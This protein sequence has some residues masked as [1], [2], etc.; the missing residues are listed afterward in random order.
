MLIEPDSPTHQTIHNMQRLPSFLFATSPEIEW[1]MVVSTTPP[2]IISKTMNFNNKNL[3]KYDAFMTRLNNNSDPFSAFFKIP[4]YRMVMI[5]ST[6]LQ[7]INAMEHQKEIRVVIQEM[8]NYY[9]QEK[10]LPNEGAFR[11]YKE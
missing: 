8:A 10:I 9:L 11:K 2:F 3:D 7:P 5:Y 1:G 4:G 6:S